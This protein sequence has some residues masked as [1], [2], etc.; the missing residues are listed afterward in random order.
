MLSGRRGR[1]TVGSVPRG[2]FRS[3]ERLPHREGVRRW[4]YRCVGRRS[5]ARISVS[6]FSRIPGISGTE[7]CDETCATQFSCRLG[8]PGSCVFFSCVTDGDDEAMGTSARV[9]DA[10]VL[11]VVPQP[12][13][14]FR[15]QAPCRC[16]PCASRTGRISCKSPRAHSLGR[17]WARG[18]SLS[19]PCLGHSHPRPAW[20]APAADSRFEN[21]HPDSSP[22]LLT[23]ILAWNN[24]NGHLHSDHHNVD[25][26]RSYDTARI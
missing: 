5:S 3:R 11:E 23:T 2:L 6:I 26:R 4:R 20:L 15:F 22:P 13:L 19:A 21:T 10:V 16:C 12:Y 24:C 17:F 9:L 1:R 7:G 8:R 14:L 25:A 18:N